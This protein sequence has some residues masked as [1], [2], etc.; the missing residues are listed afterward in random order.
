M[1][2]ADQ[3]PKTIDDYI[4]AAPKPVRPILA[5]VRDTIRKAAPRAEERIS[6]RMPAYK[7]NGDAVYFAAFKSHIGLYP[8]VEG[9]DDLRAAVAKYANEKGNLRFPLDEPIPYTLIAR[10]VKQRVKWNAQRAK[11][12][13]AGRKR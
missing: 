1:K 3:G 7:L 6:Y 10:I 9:D 12:K 5:K 11:A 8:P 4:A 2:A 13:A